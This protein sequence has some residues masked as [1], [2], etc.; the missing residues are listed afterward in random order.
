LARRSFNRDLLSIQ[1]DYFILG[2]IPIVDGW[3]FA[4]VIAPLDLFE[5][6]R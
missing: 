4:F 3:A 2:H 5:I 6:T 1:P